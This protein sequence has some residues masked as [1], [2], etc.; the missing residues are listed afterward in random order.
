[1]RLKIVSDGTPFG[2]KLVHV[3]TGEEVEGFTGV[4]WEHM[5]PGEPP[6]ANVRLINMPI[7]ATL[8][9]RRDTK[10]LPEPEK[11]PA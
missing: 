6:T 5:G 11:E 4:S 7:R 3:E 10:E 1:M 9:L 2:T 8:N